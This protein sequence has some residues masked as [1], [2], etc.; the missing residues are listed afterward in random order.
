MKIAMIF[1]GYASQ[2]VGMAKELYDES[3]LVQEYFEEASNCL[4]N[5][6]VKLC[7]ASSDSELAKM[8]HAYTA[9]FLVSSSLY[10]LLAQEGITPSIVAGVDS[11]QYAA[12]FAAQSL[13]LPDGLYL[14]NKLA[15]FYQEFL[16]GKNFAIIKVTGIDEAD[17]TKLALEA[18]DGDNVATISLYESS[19]VVYVSGPHA[20]IAQLRDLCEGR[21]ARVDHKPIEHGLHSFH[22]QPVVDMLKM[23]LEKVDFKDLTVPLINN[24][25][26]LKINLGEQV[27]T[28]VLDQIIS[29]IQWEQSMQSLKD[30]D[31]IVH[32]GPGDL[33]LQTLHYV[34]PQAKTI[35]I[36]NRADIERLKELLSPTQERSI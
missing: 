20:V 8:A 25:N 30:C 21:G 29:P 2:Y 13:S 7:F 36:N 14:L 10:S 18:S 35:A 19:S 23:Y 17:I 11:G 12:L 33:L 9:I 3:R 28:A 32:I 26:A 22:A 31:V 16:E 34:H 24:V 4:S 27:K 6:F 15:L 1:P 5:N